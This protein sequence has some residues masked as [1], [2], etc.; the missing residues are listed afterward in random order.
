MAGVYKPKGKKKYVSWWYDEHGKRRSTCAFAEK[1]LALK[2]ANDR[3]AECRQQR[4][5][6][7]PPGELSRREAARTPLA[8]HIEDYRLHLLAKGG[9]I[10]HARHVAG[11]LR[12][13]L[14]DAGV[15]QVG[16]ITADRIQGAL[17]RLKQRRAARTVNHARSAVIAFAGWLYDAGRLPEL[18]R[19]LRRLAVANEE[20]D[21]RRVRRALTRE[22]LARLL[23]VTEA[24]PDVS[25]YGCAKSRNHKRMITGPE[26][27]AIYRLAM[28]TGFRA[29]EIRSLTPEC[30][31]LEGDEPT[32]TVRAAYSK[33]GKQAVQPIARELAAAI[34]PF[35]AG[36][37]PGKPVLTVPTPT[38][39]ILRAD[40]ER[41]GIPY[42]AGGQVIDFH[43]LRTSY[44]THLIQAG[45]DVKTV[46][47]LAR[48]STPTLTIQRYA[49]TSNERKRKALEGG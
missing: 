40:L 8:K 23:A 11:V 43:A 36:K 38:A 16:E 20:A 32:V 18:P 48:H 31:Q 7:L 3:E 6:L 2:L 22:E 47:E 35:V 10:R 44:V 28:G 49:R 15:R 39:K 17:G 41:A 4:E 14:D 24:G 12:R 42:A 1:S 45:V 37:P 9:T 25:M 34:R 33:N 26:R 27:A 21:R 5:G 13:L 46:Q 19:G 30:F 29:N